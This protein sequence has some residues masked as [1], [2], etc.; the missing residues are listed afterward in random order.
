MQQNDRLLVDRLVAGD[1]EA[2]EEL[3]D[4]YA[5]LLMAIARRVTGDGSSAE[6]VVQEVMCSLWHHPERFDER[7][8]SLR[9]YLGMQAHRRAVD[10]LRADSRRR[11]RE[12]RFESVECTSPS[13]LP[14]GALPVDDATARELVHNAIARL[15]DE[16]RRA[17]SLAFFDGHSYREVAVL[18]G[19]PEG[20]AK[21]R[22]RLAQAKLAQWLAPMAAAR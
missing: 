20:T 8:G 7:R 18:L 9:A 12:R 22:L 5:G 2:V 10:L 19:I 6:D 11:G 21:S 3:F 16:Q 14:D 1:D 17:V 13:W 4:R 15:P